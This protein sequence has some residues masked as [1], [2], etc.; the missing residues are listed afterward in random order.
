MKKILIADD[1]EFNRDILKEIFSE[2]YEIFEAGDGE[3]AVRCIRENFES[4]SLIFLDLMMPK[5]SGL[6]V[7]EI[8][9]DEGYLDL[10]PVIIITGEATVD[11]DAAAYDYG[12]ADIIYKPFARRVI[13]R[14][15]LNIIELYERRKNLELQ[16]DETTS[17]LLASRKK[18]AENNEFLVN[19]LSSVVEFRSLESGIH[20]NRVKEFTDV[21]LHTWA[22]LHSDFDY[23]ELDIRQMVNASAL[24][25]IGKISIPDEI[26]LK[27]GRLTLEAFAIMK[28]HTT[29]GCE[30]LEKFKQEDSDFYQYC[31]DIC[32]YHHERYDGKGYPDHLKGDEIP[33]WAQ[34]VSIADVFDALISPR[35]YKVP[36]A[37]PKAVD[38]IFNGEC[39]TFSPKLLECFESAKFKLIEIAERD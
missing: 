36:Y 24:H 17:E 19:A 30:I 33:V 18:L 34:V 3:E 25:D 38:M 2:Q 8:M 28:E 23:K 6:D 31:Y 10:I 26:L 1:A 20:I 14:R 9:K 22:A 16:L 4:L 21:L 7:L 29:K 5:M 39:G 35:C 27:P 11:T 12:V 37:I 13:T 15:A 32:R